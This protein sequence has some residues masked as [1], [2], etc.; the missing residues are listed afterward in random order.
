[1]GFFSDLFDFNRDGK[2]DCFERTARDV[3]I[4]GIIS[5]CENTREVPESA[6]NRNR[7]TFFSDNEDFDLLNDAG[8]DEFDLMSMDEDER[9]DALEAAGLDPD[10]FFFD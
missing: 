8:L 3:F 9:R 6:F 4:M 5:S 1:M 10:D 2:L 7:R